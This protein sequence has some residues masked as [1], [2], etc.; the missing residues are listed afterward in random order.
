[1]QHTTPSSYTSS[2]LS[3]PGLPPHWRPHKKAD[4]ET[5]RAL[6][7]ELK[8]HALTA[9]LLALRGLESPE[10]AHTFLSPS[11]RHLP[12]PTRM[13]G[14]K[15]ACQR[16]LQAL[17]HNERIVI[18]GDYDVD[19]V[20]STSLLYL[21]LRDV[22]V[23]P[24]RLHT[25]IPHR[26]EHGYGLQ[27]KCFPDI[28]QMGCDLMLTVDCGISSREEI[29]ELNQLG[30]DVIVV[31]HHI[32]PETLPNAHTIL[33]P[34]QLDCDYP[35]KGLAAVGVTYQLL[36]ALRAAMREEGFFQER[37][38]PN[39]KRYLDI[40]ALGTVADIVP[41]QGVN[42]IM[43]YHGL[44]QMQHTRW[45]G[46]RAL[47]Q[48]SGAKPDQ[49]TAESIG[50]RLGPRINAVG[51]LSHASLGVQMLTCPDYQEAIALG[52]QLDHENT[53][54]R[55]L[56]ES[57]YQEAKQ[58]LASNPA[59]QEEYGIVLSSPNWHL[60]VVG[61]VASKLLEQWH[62]PVI[63][64]AL[65]QDKGIGKGSA[66]SIDAFH[67]YEGLAAC[68]A[69]LEKFGGHKAAAGLTLSLD[70]LDNFRRAFLA[71]LRDTLTPADLQPT[72]TYDVEF[73]PALLTPALI[74]DLQRLAPYGEA[75]PPPLLAAAGVS[76]RNQRKTQ[77]GRHL[78]LTVARHT[79]AIAFRQG[80]LYP[81]PSTVAL[82]YRPQFNEWKGRRNIQLNV[83]KI[84]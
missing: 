45:P 18:Y 78:Q 29:D 30:F 15:R 47:I 26:I 55:A 34:R 66:R 31:D 39:L 13:K 84:E 68:D 14:M 50:F 54:R 16:L 32:P 53:Q 75:N 80:D 79:R 41:L 27:P 60:G 82:A 56:Q 49:L 25:Y 9:Q 71:H 23:S 77:D 83:K 19:G 7:H 3:A 81:L 62:R 38:E 52:Y 33:N 67:I 42:R 65:D 51:R 1:M 8:L 17:R 37:P 46:L 70:Q 58:M 28:V 59:L 40:V 11:L 24:D 64:L 10:L 61:I 44:R 12:D 20:S 76:V 48:V 2:P 69:Y 22:G 4:P 5:V 21:F 36:I 63:L 73:D 74:E 57:V 6:Q 35:D 43:V 72:L